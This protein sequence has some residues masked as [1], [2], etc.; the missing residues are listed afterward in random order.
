[1]I[2]FAKLP[3]VRMLTPAQY[4]VLAYLA[5]GGWN[6]VFGMGIYALAYWLFGKDVNYLV[7]AIPT[8]ILAIS[9]AFLCYKLFVFRTKGNWLRE[10][11]RCFLVYGGGTLLGMGLLWFFVHVFAINPVIANIAGTVLV[12]IGSFLGHKYFS[13]RKDKAKEN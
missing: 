13:F 7:L 10:Y 4:E 9:N 11:F 5:V 6:T 3:I 8:N 1:M 12:V 2:D